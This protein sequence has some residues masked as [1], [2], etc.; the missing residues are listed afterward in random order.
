MMMRF[1]VF[2]AAR[3]SD[4]LGEAPVVLDGGRIIAWVDIDTARWHRLTI[5]TGTVETVKMPTALTGFAPA[6]GGG[7]IGA[8]VDGLARFDARG[9]RD[10]LHRPEAHLPS[11][12]FND[13]GCD[14]VGR[15]LAGTMN[16]NLDKPN[17]SV[18]ALSEDGSLSVLRR[19]VTVANTVAFS[20]EGDIIYLAD[21]VADDLGAWRYDADVGQIAA[22]VPGF[23]QPPGLPGRPDGSAVDA[24]GHIWT[25]RWGG[26]CIQRL[27][28]DGRPT[29]R[30][31][32]PV[33]CPTSCAFLG[34]TLF[35][36][37]ATRALDVVALRKEP[38]AG[39][40]L[41][42]HVGV[43]GLDVATF[44]GSGQ[45]VAPNELGKDAL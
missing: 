10:V 34:E 24:E 38:L 31:D 13:A 22:R 15:F 2:V 14:P 7:F 1:E 23:S 16:T 9:R 39:C 44:A 5:S 18:Y 35:I 42:A 40:L 19:D 25:A 29:C 28:P 8:F 33:S 36:T 17:A 11:N 3:T 45:I 43:R 20:P 37:T 41:A 12:R 27:S 30:L 4:R 21:T 6:A 26:G 32:L